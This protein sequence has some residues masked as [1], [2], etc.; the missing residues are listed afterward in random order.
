[1]TPQMSTGNLQTYTG[2]SIS[3]A[4]VSLEVL[5]PDRRKVGGTRDLGTA[6]GGQSV[7]AATTTFSGLKP[8]TRHAVVV[9]TPSTTIARRCFRTPADLNRALGWHDDVRRFAGGC[10]A[11]GLTRAAERACL[12]GARNRNDQWA[13]TG[14]VEPNGQSFDSR[15]SDDTIY[16]WILSAA[17]RTR[18]GCDN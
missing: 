11:A 7:P 17:E 8:G 16:K 1:M 14:T 4:L 9:R 12:C 3:F 6:G 13:R 18:L 15:L 2:R 5:G 10:F